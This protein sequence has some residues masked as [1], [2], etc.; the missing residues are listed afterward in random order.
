M[1]LDNVASI[2]SSSEVILHVSIEGASSFSSAMMRFDLIFLYYMLA[3][4]VAASKTD[5]ST[6]GIYVIGSL[7]PTAT[8]VKSSPAVTTQKS[9]T[10]FH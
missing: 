7:S 8:L 10:I 1:G 9:T 2:S 6:G 4:S 3:F 5:N